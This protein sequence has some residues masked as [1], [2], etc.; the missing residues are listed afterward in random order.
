M[1]RREVPLIAVVDDDEAVRTAIANLVRSLGFS[2]AIFASAEAFL[3]CAG[4]GRESCVI[5]DVQMPGMSGLELQRHLI[6]TGRGVPVILITAFP[7]EHV[8]DQAMAAGA[9][10]FLGKPF[11]GHHLIDC[12]GKALG[13]ARQPS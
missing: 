2:A 6:A 7:G 13:G 3:A 12:I 4:Y 1:N 5:A 9:V 10:G 11:E 8:R